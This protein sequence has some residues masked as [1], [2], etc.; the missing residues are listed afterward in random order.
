[1]RERVST[2]VVGLLVAQAAVPLGVALFMIITTVVPIL[3]ELE[4]SLETAQM[5]GNL[6]L[7]SFLAGAFG[8][9]YT[10]PISLVI[11]VPMSLLLA[12]Y[13]VLSVFGIAVVAVLV[14]I[15]VVGLMGMNIGA[16]E[17]YELTW[18]PVIIGT[19]IYWTY[20]KRTGV[21]SRSSE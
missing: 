20:L 12:R 6:I 19:I 3:H 15:V 21:A 10:T 9:L 16:L 14:A 17:S 5:L 18:L 11:G 1:M 7:L 13:G 8:L 2:Y 4:L